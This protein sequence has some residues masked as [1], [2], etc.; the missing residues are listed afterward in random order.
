MIKK[1]LT[2]LSQIDQSIYQ[3]AE[4]GTRYFGYGGDFGE[5]VHDDNFCAN[6]LLLPDR[7]LQPEMAEVRYQYSQ[8]KFDAF[9][10]DHATVRMKNY[11]LFT[12]VAEKYEFRWSITADA[13]VAAEGVLPANAVRVANVDART[14]Q[15][16]ERVVTLNLPTIALIC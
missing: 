11:F 12:D 1:T 15:P 6:G 13:D 2:I 14:N 3:T 10:E 5:R 16:G 4:D 8:L 9:D 7:T